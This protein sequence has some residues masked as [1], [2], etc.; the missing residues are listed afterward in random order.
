MS[1]TRTVARSPQ[2]NRPGIARIGD[3]YESVLAMLTPAM[4][5]RYE[6]RL[7]HGFYDG[8]RPSRGELIDEIALDLALINWAEAQERRR[9]RRLGHRVSDLLPRVRERMRG[10]VR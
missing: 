10:R 5:R 4:R 9:K 1:T 3:H 7:T 6:L 8:W 2:L